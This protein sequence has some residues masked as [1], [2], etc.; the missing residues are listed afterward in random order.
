MNGGTTDEGSL[1]RF[2]FCGAAGARK[3]VGAKC[4]PDEATSGS[5]WTRVPPALNRAAKGRYYCSLPE[6]PGG[7][8]CFKNLSLHL[9]P[10]PK[11]AIS[12]RTLMPV[13]SLTNY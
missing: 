10:R 12:V 11:K 4:A 5:E 6:V 9:R 1:Y 3:G 7:A 2:S 13:T 8:P